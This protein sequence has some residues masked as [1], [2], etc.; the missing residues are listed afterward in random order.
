[1]KGFKASAV[2][3]LH[4]AFSHGVCSKKLGDFSELYP[5]A[6]HSTNR[7]G[8]ACSCPKKVIDLEYISNHM[9]IVCTARL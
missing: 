7:R 3:Q 5:P 8:S 4:F 1:M 6:W 9:P 2:E